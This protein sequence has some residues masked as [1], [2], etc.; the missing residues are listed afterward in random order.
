MT[1]LVLGSI[2]KITSVVI[3]GLNDVVLPFTPHVLGDTDA[4]DTTPGLDKFHATDEHKYFIKSIDGLQPPP[5]N[6]AIAATAGGGKFQGITSEEREIVVLIGLNPDWD[7]GETP[8]LLR[9]NLETLLYTGY[10]PRADIICM[11][12]VFPLFH[13][14]GYVSNFE[15][16]IFDANPVVQVTFTMLNPNFKGMFQT[17]YSAADLSE[18]NPDVYNNA[19]A[20]TGFQFGVIFTG[21]MAEWSIKQSERQAIGMTFKKPSGNFV[22]GD[23]LFISTVPGQKFIHFQHYKGKVKNALGYLTGDSEWIQL[24]PGHNHFV[25]PKKVGRWDWKGPLTFWPRY[26]GI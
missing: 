11:A 2:P 7:A 4:F 14:Y 5:R 13:E 20:E 25:V 10:D 3:R 17:F 9:Q 18:T 23:K 6:V 1:N 15:A 12:G 16:A 21:T 22:A 19:T 24:H 8:S 26:S